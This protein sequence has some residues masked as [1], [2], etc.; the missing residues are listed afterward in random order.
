VAW[1]QDWVKK[2]G[3]KNMDNA[4][5][6]LAK[7]R[8]V[9]NQGG[10]HG[11]SDRYAFVPTTRV[12]DI[13]GDM[14]WYPVAAQCAKVRSDSRDGYQKHA[15]RFENPNLTAV[16]KRDSD[17]AP[18]ILLRN[19]H[20]RSGCFELRLGL[21]RFVCSNGLVVGETFEKFKVRHIG[22]A[23]QAVEEA[24]TILTAQAPK[25]LENV[26]AMRERHLSPPERL[27]FAQKALDMKF[28]GKAY[29]FHPADILQARRVEDSEF[30]LWNT[31]NCVQEAL[32]KG[33]SRYRTEKGRRATDRPIRAIE[34]NIDFNKGLWSLAESF[35]Q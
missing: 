28:D 21:F 32:V 27:S 24:V 31:F 35:L 18:Q 29:V 30:N 20:D 33:G 11:V 3:N 6:N 2:K 9:A 19:S 12:A 13:L 16:A 26:V 15:V 14:S 34:R 4:I 23:H 8:A 7:Y 25:V 22:F 17:V 10:G 1:C 5:I